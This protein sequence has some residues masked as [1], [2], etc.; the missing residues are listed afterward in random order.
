MKLPGIEGKVAIVTGAGG[1][2]G[3]G[4]AKG[5][6]AAGRA[7]RRRRD[8]Q[9]E[10]RARRRGDP[11][12]RRAGAVRRGGRLVADLDEGG[13][14][15]AP[16]RPSAASTSSSTT[17][18]S[19]ARMKMS[20]L[21]DVDWDYYKRFMD[22]NM[23]GALLCTRA[24]APEMAKRGGGAI[25]NQSSTAAWMSVGLLRPREARA[26]RP[27][28]VRSRA[29]SARRRSA[30]TRSRPARPTPRRCAPWCPRSSRSSSSR[31]CALPRLGTPDDLVPT[32]LF[33]LSDAAAWMTGQVVN[34]DGG[35][36]MRPV[37]RGDPIDGTRPPRARD[38]QPDRRPPR[39]RRATARRSRT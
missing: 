14:P 36:I 4:Y 20:S 37:G 15:S 12:E 18:P 31:R 11:Q 28:A 9:G 22:V 1:G 34:V 13:W 23:H 26:E 29:S 21:I 30:S 5:L 17:P 16:S 39:R 32:C 2:I 10:G 35:Q 7:R 19:S 6:A 24:C 8:R 27:H 3:E 33:L 38:A 25:V